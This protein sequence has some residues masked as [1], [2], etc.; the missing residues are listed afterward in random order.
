MIGAQN[1]EKFFRSGWG[2][3]YIN[4]NLKHTLRLLAKLRENNRD[5]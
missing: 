5:R 1:R 3:A 4:K 2:R